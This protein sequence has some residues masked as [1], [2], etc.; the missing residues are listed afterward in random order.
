MTSKECSCDLIDLNDG[1]AGET[2][3]EMDAAGS[4]GGCQKL[5]G[6]LQ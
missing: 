4:L 2:M 3:E 1:D 6:E 5:E